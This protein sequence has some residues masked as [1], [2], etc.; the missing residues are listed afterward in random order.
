MHSPGLHLKQ[1]YPDS[2]QQ[3]FFLPGSLNWAYLGSAAAGGAA[4]LCLDNI[5]FTY[6]HLRHTEYPHQ[7]SKQLHPAAGL[8]RAGINAAQIAGNKLDYLCI[9]K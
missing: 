6:N 7:V 2:Q 8:I 3:A 1:T 4:P 9:L 5:R